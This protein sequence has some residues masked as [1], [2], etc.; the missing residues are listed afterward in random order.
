[1]RA[2]VNSQLEFSPGSPKVFILFAFLLFFLGVFTTPE[3]LISLGPMRP[4]LTSYVPTVRNIANAEVLIIRLLCIIFA[5]SLA[6]IAITWRRIQG[7]SLIKRINDYIPAETARYKARRRLFNKSL[8]VITVCIGTGMLYMG[9]GSRIFSLDQLKMI[10]R[11]DGIIEYATVLLFMMCTLISAILSFR[12]SS[13]KARL[14]MHAFFAFVFF[15][16][17]CEEISWGQRIFHFD[18]FEVFQQANIQSENNLHNLYGR[19]IEH[20]F[21]VSVFIYGFILPLLAHINVFYYKL[22]DLMG[23]PIGSLGLAIGF[24]MISMLHPWTVYWILTPAAGL[25]IEELR[26][27]FTALAFSLL[28]YESWALS[29]MRARPIHMRSL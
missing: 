26:E 25:K 6:A 21:I 17:A 5:I 13:R 16:I 20:I 22:F 24:F 10:N 2:C 12:F 18:T 23:L 14:V 1:M 7:T 4:S 29:K 27:L 28:M 15:F 3:L 8:V 19:F 9:V 11:E